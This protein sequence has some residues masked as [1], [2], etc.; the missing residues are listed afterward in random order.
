MNRVTVGEVALWFWFPVDLITNLRKNVDRI[1]RVRS[2][3]LKKYV[4]NM[5]IYVLISVGNEI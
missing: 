5:Q 4:C 2:N 3:Q 1:N